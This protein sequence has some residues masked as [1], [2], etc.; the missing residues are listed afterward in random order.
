MV[1]SINART[2]DIV[3]TVSLYYPVTRPD[4]A[5]EQDPVQRF[6][7][8]I[9][10]T[11]PNAATGESTSSFIIF[12]TLVLPVAVA[13]FCCMLC[14]A[15]CL[16]AREIALDYL[17][18]CSSCI[19]RKTSCVQCMDHCCGLEDGKG[20]P[21]PEKN[22]LWTYEKDESGKQIWYQVNSSGKRI[23]PESTASTTATTHKSFYNNVIDDFR[24]IKNGAVN[25]EHQVANSLRDIGERTHLLPKTAPQTA[26]AAGLSMRRTVFE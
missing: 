5:Q 22:G 11:D 24:Y 7:V 17:E 21:E 3:I 12:M 13:A 4:F 18:T 10:T 2:E 15:P 26:P 6:P 14:F 8:Q 16:L 9:I 25:L 19:C 1:M 20:K 23:Q